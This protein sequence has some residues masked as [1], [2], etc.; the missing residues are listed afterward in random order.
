MTLFR[1]REKAPHGRHLLVESHVRLGSFV[2]LLILS[3]LCLSFWGVRHRNPLA[4][5][6]S[7]ALTP[8]QSAVSQWVTRG[9]D[10]ILSW[11]ELMEVRR[12]AGQVQEENQRLRRE[13]ALLRSVESE[14]QRLRRLHALADQQ[15]SKTLPAA[16]I[17][18]GEE[19]FR[20]LLL[21]RGSLSEVAERQPVITYAG[22]VGHVVAVQPHACK[23]LEITDP[24]S[25]IGVFVAAT[26]DEASGEVIL[27][28]V[29]GSG[30][31]GL[32][33]EPRGGVDVPAGLPVYTSSTSTIY[34]SG[35]LVGWVR[36][37]LEG[38]YTLQRR[39]RV[40]PAVDFS[41]LREVLILL[42]LHRH[43][44]VRLTEQSE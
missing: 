13:L 2:L 38:G 44:T 25:A 42:G 19:Q 24:N 15:P 18:R 37:S 28:V 6:F 27:G 31:H 11:K 26:A 17:G 23:V 29:S 41:R 16:V 5:G 33:L 40:E 36:E 39:L 21:D 7:F 4:E 12:Q 9:G 35:L 1:Y 10:R 43:E 20:T 3:L 14:N 22:L 34:P 32:V 8:L 30:A